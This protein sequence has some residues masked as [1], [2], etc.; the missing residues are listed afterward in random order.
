MDSRRVGPYE[1][2]REQWLP[3]PLD[4]VF[5]FFSRP[6]NLQEITPPWLD[7]R[8]VESPR[9]LKSGSLIRYRL[10]WHWMPIRW[11]TEIAQWNPPQGFVDRAVSSPYALW[12][13]EH[14]F[15]AQAGGTM[16]RDRVTYAL[17]LAALG[18][19]AHWAWVKRD[20]ERIFDFRAEAMRRLFPS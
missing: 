20:V 12:N 19:F 4:E 17:P 7:F 13:H 2:K 14:I 16:M 15:E 11:T 9:S 18:R 8:M 5:E 10:R 1:L 6:E 3:R